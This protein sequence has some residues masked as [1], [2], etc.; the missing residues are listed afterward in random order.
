MK[1]TD[2]DLRELRRMLAVPDER[3]FPPGRMRQREEHMMNSVTGMSHGPGNRRRG[4][5]TRRWVLAGTG[6]AAVAGAAMMLLN[7]SSEPAYAVTSNS[8]G[9][10]TITVNNIGDPA[11]AN[12]K[13]QKAGVP[14][15]VM[16]PKAATNC[17]ERD[18]A[19]VTVVSFKQ[20]NFATD[21]VKAPDFLEVV[22]S[23]SRDNEVRIRPNEIPMDQI[24]IVSP[25][26]SKAG[27]MIQ[28][29][30]APKP[31]PK[32]VIS[33]VDSWYSPPAPS[34]SGTARPAPSVSGTASPNS[35]AP[36]P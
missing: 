1:D 23:T 11:D 27:P 4:T 29:S 10:V 30:V 8:D 3:D 22:G 31:G 33:S 7:P 16:L 36:T 12:R 13:L 19:G 28:V 9:T 20:S 34:L 6:L 17:P 35:A 5:R 18:R 25:I 32:C 14:A 2:A 24:V 21:L 15:I 26:P